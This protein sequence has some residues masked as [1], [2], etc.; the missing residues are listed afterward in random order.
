M[1]RARSALC[2][3]RLLAALA[4]LL[5]VAG[6]AGRARAEEAL[7]LEVFINDIPTQL[8]G[9]FVLLEGKRIASRQHELEEIG[10]NPKGHAEPDKLVTLDDLAGVSY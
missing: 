10:L 7:Q 3:A 6:T 2:V 4:L 8:I 5:A 1:S 9:A